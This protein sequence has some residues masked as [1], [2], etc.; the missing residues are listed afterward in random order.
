[1][2]HLDRLHCP[3]LV[4]YGGNESPE[5]QRH[6]RDFAAA[7]EKSGHPHTLVRLAGSNHFEG[8]A[9]LSDPASE[10]SQLLL[11]HMGLQPA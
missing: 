1:M 2:R 4:T 6:A 7:M 5:F 3:V 8:L 9:S 11:R 10:V